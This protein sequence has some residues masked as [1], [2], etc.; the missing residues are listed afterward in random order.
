MDWIERIFGVSPD[1]GSGTL[2][3]VYLAVAALGTAAFVFRRRI[4]GWA[5]ARRR[6]DLNH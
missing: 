6:R 1:G 2:E 3:V 5:R 4:G